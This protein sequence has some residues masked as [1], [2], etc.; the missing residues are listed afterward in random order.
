[1]RIEQFEIDL[2]LREINAVQAHSHRIAQLP[3]ASGALTH[4]PHA[5]AL[6]FPVI[7]RNR[8]NMHQSIDG[9]FLQLHEQT[10]LERSIYRHLRYP[11][12][13]R[14]A[15]SARRSRCELSAPKVCSSAV[16]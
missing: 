1:M 15:S 10:E 11:I 5:A 3:A 8:G 6:E 7:A 4:Q 13:S 16:V 14:E 9:H 2:P 12:T